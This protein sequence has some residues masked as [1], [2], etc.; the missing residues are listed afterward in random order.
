[1]SSLFVVRHGQASFQGPHYD[2]L[3]PLGERQAQALAAW[4]CS[5][6][7]RWDYVFIGPKKR[8]RQTAEAAAAVFEAAGLPFPEPVM[9]P[10]FDEHHGASV[11]KQALSNDHDNEDQAALL[12]GH[13]RK[14]ADV[15]AYFRRFQE[16][17]T[18][19]VAGSHTSEFETWQAFRARVDAGLLEVTRQA[20]RGARSV[21]FSSGGPVAVTTGAALKL[22]D[23]AVLEMS[24]KVRNGAYSE[25]IYQDTR[26]TLLSHNATPGFADKALM[27]FI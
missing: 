20:G 2:Q 19:W 27:T 13:I 12:P 15:D 26:L 5:H 22:S 11:V 17:T 9:L 8:H 18:A 24:W 16:I 25:C 7:V 6:D 14:Q 23:Q 10:A 1:M 21:V 3:S 4:W